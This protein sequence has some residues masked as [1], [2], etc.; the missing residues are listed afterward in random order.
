M[1]KTRVEIQLTSLLILSTVLVLL[2]ATTLLFHEDGLVYEN[3]VQQNAFLIQRLPMDAEKFIREKNPMYLENLLET[4]YEVDAILR[5]MSEGGTVGLGSITLKRVG[6]PLA[7]AQMQSFEDEFRNHKSRINVLNEY[8]LTL[9]SE[10][11]S[12]VALENAAEE[13]SMFL[14]ENNKTLLS[15]NQ[16]ISESLLSYFA[17]R[18][19]RLKTVLAI[20]TLAVILLAVMA[21]ALI[22]QKI[23]APLHRILAKAIKI[24]QGSYS[25]Q[26]NAWDKLSIALE[27]ID[28]Q[29][30]EA[31]GF[32][33]SVGEGK[34]DTSLNL[35]GD[36]S[37]L[38]NALLDMRNRLTRFTE[39]ENRQKWYNEGI[40][41]ITNVLSE[42]QVKSDADLAYT[43]VKALTKH[44]DVN[45][46]A[47][48]AADH[49]KK[50][51][52]MLASHAFEKRKYRDR[53]I[54]LGEG[55]IGECMAE[56]QKIYVETIPENYLLITSGLGE[57][58]PR[59]LLLM[60][61]MSDSEVMGVVETA[62]FQ[63]I[64]PYKQL[65]VE[66]ACARY[67]N[68]LTAI[69]NNRRTLRMLEESEK[70]NYSLREKEEAMR[71][72]ASDLEYIQRELNTKLEELEK[73]TNLSRNIVE[74][75]NKT[76]ATVE[77]DMRG[78]ILAV[79]NMYLSIMGYSQNELIGQNE[80]M[81]VPELEQDTM[82]FNLLWDSLSNGSYISGE[83]RRLNKFGREVW[84]NGTYNPI[85]GV[86]RKPYKVIQLA[87][88]T[89]E[90]KEKD[91][92][93]T[94]KLNALGSAFPLVDI[95]PEGN[96]LSSNQMF[97]QVFGFKRKDIRNKQ[98]ADFLSPESKEVFGKM[99]DNALED[100]SQ[101]AILEFVSAY[102]TATYCVTSL[103]PIKNL[104]GTI[105]K[106][107]TVLIDVTEQKNLELGLV[108][109]KTK[110]SYTVGKLERLQNDLQMQKNE[111]ETRIG[112]LNRSS[113][114]FEMDI[115]GDLTMV[116]YQLCDIF[117]TDRSDLLNKSF[118]S[119]VHPASADLV[120]A[121]DFPQEIADN[122]IFKHT[123]RY[124]HGEGRPF[125]C[126]T[127]IAALTDAEGYPIKYLGIMFD[128]SKMVNTENELR[129]SLAQ[130]RAKN[131]ML[132]LDTKTEG[133]VED[134]LESLLADYEKGGIDTLMDNQKAPTFLLNA[135][136][137]VTGFNSLASQMF[138]DSL[139]KTP[140]GA[141]KLFSFTDK[142]EEE[143]LKSHFAEGS[144][145]QQKALV[146][147]P[148]GHQTMTV[149]TLPLFFGDGM[150]PG[151]VLLLT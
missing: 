65:F 151:T 11:R 52:V 83:Y 141:T 27:R 30:N 81:L 59:S 31:A 28:G 104:S 68:V 107:F 93:Y 58:P 110:L 69:Q 143:R 97:S 51:C 125:W 108:E 119:I 137:E 112:M 92:D 36:E 150:T 49:D 90:D 14:S 73:E 86:D 85:F 105:Y 34:F 40:T 91:L 24:S 54:P 100:Q 139:P 111:L 50:A 37:Q 87:Q 140:F 70:L 66:Q 38:G 47:V 71:R 131:A 122:K 124:R 62:S 12:S 148:G 82:S 84:L 35:L 44:L 132:R 95:N 130:E 25:A 76:S 117:E 103:N 120:A 129:E 5:A 78:N 60:P 123:L 106:V 39:E 75:I 6:D 48:F 147:L 32:V 121:E 3:A 13:A 26:L 41:H 79:N 99:W 63:P 61:V 19:M 67:A 7:L 138:A 136:G 8:A 116:N 46:S 18:A 15:I 33:H 118:K 1:Q 126:D 94:S 55:L 145:R 109:Q 22:W 77:F 142:T 17:A 128:V 115:E 9:S 101:A 29:I 135:Q 2:T 146:S 113:M 102:D 149:V 4:S 16:N 127:T 21:L 89:T 10:V 72:N 98:F 23:V 45:Q 144:L 88:F 134:I 53:E 42:N 96:V 57:A 56:K 64:P 43:F 80:R 74:A 20:L 133:N 114:I